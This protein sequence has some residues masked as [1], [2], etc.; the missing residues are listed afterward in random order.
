[1]EQLVTRML[2]TNLYLCE[3]HIVHTRGK[4]KAV[5]SG[6]D[7]VNSQNLSLEILHRIWTWKLVSEILNF[8]GGRSGL[9]W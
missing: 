6:V 1:M 8:C 9:E 2:L 3:R 7:S 5:Y 4:A